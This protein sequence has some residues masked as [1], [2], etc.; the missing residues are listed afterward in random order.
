MDLLDEKEK[1]IMDKEIEDFQ[2]QF[3]KTYGIHLLVSYRVKSMKSLNVTISELD[4]MIKDDAKEYYPELVAV[5]PNFTR[6]KTRNGMLVT[7]RQILHYLA[8]ES[9]YTLTYIAK[10]C[11]FH[12]ASVIH[13]CKTVDDYLIIKDKKV[14]EIFNR[15]KNE[16]KNRYGYDGYV[17]HDFRKR[18]ES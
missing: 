4:T 15:I 8:R 18:A 9:G 16:I 5:H 1:E 2:N 12:H 14:V 17:Q 6:E 11:G 10:Y 7:Y 3:Y 13:G